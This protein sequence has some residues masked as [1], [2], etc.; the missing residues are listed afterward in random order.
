MLQSS[1]NAAENLVDSRTETRRPSANI[2]CVRY[3]PKQS[4]LKACTQGDITKLYWTE[5]A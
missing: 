1:M 2:P 4:T 3:P 5:L